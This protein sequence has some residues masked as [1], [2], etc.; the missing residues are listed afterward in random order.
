MTFSHWIGV[1]LV[2][3]LVAALLYIGLA[4]SGQAWLRWPSLVTMGLGFLAHTAAISARASAA[5]HLPL[6]N[7]Y[8]TLL[9]FAW[10]LVPLSY[11]LERRYRLPALN[12]FTMPLVAV[13]LA[14]LSLLSSDIEPLM[15]SLKSNWLLVH[16]LA[17][18]VAY[19]AFGVAFVASVVLVISK[20]LKQSEKRQRRLELL[21]AITYRAITF[22]FP[23]LT[24]G[25]V[26]GAVWA[27]TCWGRY[28][29]WDPKETWSLVTW[30]IYGIF[31]HLRLTTRWQGRWA[32]W[33]SI[34]GFVAVMVTYLGVNLL[35]A[36]YLH[37]YS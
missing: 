20:R 19:A 36:G 30:L 35:Y 3:Y 28:W 4:V 10:V 34:G 33:A 32:A 14:A 37:A 2:L 31:L 18:F 29:N 21:D 24:L 13:A 16:V 26:T 6:T 12:A 25:I 27:N 15:P 8:E 5:H 7:T 22:G 17:C 1:A 11:A 9:V 23:L